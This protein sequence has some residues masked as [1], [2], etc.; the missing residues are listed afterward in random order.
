MA[1]QLHT[2]IA[3]SQLQVSGGGHMF[4]FLTE[5]QAFLASVDESPSPSD[6]H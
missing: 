2:G 1:K 3:G 6:S 5:R 4:S